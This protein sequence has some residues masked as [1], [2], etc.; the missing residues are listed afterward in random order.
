MLWKIAQVEFNE[1]HQYLIVAGNKQQLEPLLAEV[2]GYFCRHAGEVISRDRFIEDVWQGRTVTDNAVNRVI[3]KLRKLLGDDPT[4][5][6]Y[7]VTLPKKGYRLIADAIEVQERADS[8]SAVSK[9]PINA[10][11]K[12][13]FLWLL[14]GVAVLLSALIWWPKSS[15]SVVQIQA[16]TQEGAPEYAPAVSP[17]GSYLLYSMHKEGEKLSLHLKDLTSQQHLELNTSSGWNGPAA[18]AKDGKSLVYLNTTDELCRYI[19]LTVDGMEVVDQ[20]DIYH[21]PIG[22]YG[23][24]IFSHQN[25]KMIFAERADVDAP[26]FIYIL[27]LTSADKQLIPQPSPLLGGNSLFDL[28]PQ[29]NKLLISSPNKALEEAFYQV[30]LGSG[31]VKNLFSLDG[32]LCC[33]IWSHSGEQVIM[34]SAPPSTQLLS[35]ALDGQN[36]QVIYS[37]S[38]SIGPPARA[39]NG[40]DYVYSGSD[41]NRDIFLLDPQQQGGRQVLVSNSLDDRLP[42]L[43]TD[44]NQLAYVST[45]MGKQQIWLRDLQ[46]SNQRLLSDFKNNQQFFAMEW[47]PDAQH[48]AVSTLQKLFIVDN[49]SGEL[50]HIVL[51]L[52]EITSISFRNA[53][54]LTFTQKTN[55]RWR[56][57]TYDLNTQ[58]VT[59]LNDDKWAFVLFAPDANDSLWADREGKLFYGEQKIPLEQLWPQVSQLQ[60]LDNKVRK[61]QDKLYYLVG[62]GGQS[63]LKVTSLTEKQTSELMGFN[64]FHFSVDFSVNDKKVVFTHAVSKGADI[65]QLILH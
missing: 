25:G 37:A 20:Q 40:R 33:G 62:E 15:S 48:L 7:I 32:F 39:A 50:Q 26:Y 34:M 55:G 28:H 49:N 29:Q 11:R 43:S 63:Q 36:P 46:S 12:V 61:Q 64:S 56:I 31:L 38:H 27:D 54:T 4:K 8:Q 35:Y 53:H 21:C 6:T 52:A 30:D 41:F 45:T 47:S 19:L 3:A 44:G 14:A 10:P 17:D 57:Y 42:R 58:L 9:I 65:Y 51:P 5:P 16:L 59:P 60:L 2:L 1:K 13:L 23:K 22:S 18:W 24:M